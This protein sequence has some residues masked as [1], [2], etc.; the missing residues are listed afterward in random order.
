MKLLSFLQIWIQTLEL[1]VQAMLTLFVW[2]FSRID[3]IVVDFSNVNPH[4]RA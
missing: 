1:K 4:L 2:G 3:D